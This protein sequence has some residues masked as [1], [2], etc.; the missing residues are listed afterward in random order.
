M[1][2]PLGG[3]G[4]G[5]GSPFGSPFGFSP[6]GTPGVSF[7]GGGFGINPVDILVLGGVAYGVTQLVKVSQEIR[8]WK[9]GDVILEC[10]PFPPL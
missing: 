4:Y 6:F 9:P 1:P 10:P 5:F 2:V 7:Y 8:D 3:Y